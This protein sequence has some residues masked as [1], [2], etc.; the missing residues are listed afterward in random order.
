MKLYVNGAIDR[1][2]HK[3]FTKDGENVEYDILT[4]SSEDG[5]SMQLNTK[6]DFSQYEGKAATL[7]FDVQKNQYSGK[8]YQLKLIEAKPIMVDNGEGTIK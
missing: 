5:E 3:K 2:E 8:F 1:I 4:I 7:V 6:T